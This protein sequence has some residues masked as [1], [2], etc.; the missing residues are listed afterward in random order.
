MDEMTSRVQLGKAALGEEVQD[1]PP[2]LCEQ[3]HHL[4]KNAAVLSLLTRFR[5]N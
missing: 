3:F 2:P 4:E 5:R 1:V